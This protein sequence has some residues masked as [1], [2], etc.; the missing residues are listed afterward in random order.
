MARTVLFIQHDWEAVPGYVGER[1]A[2]RGLETTTLTI[3]NNQAETNRAVDFGE[4]GR[5]DVIVPLGSVFSV[6]DND[7]IGNWIGPELDFL[8]R[9]HAEDIPILGI[10]FG[11]QALAAAL[12]G[13]VEQSPEPE[14][15]W[16]RFESDRPDEL[17]EGPWMQWHYDR[18]SVPDGATELARSSVGPQAFTHGRSLGLQFHPEVSFEIVTSWLNGAPA[19][20]L[21]KPHV[22]VDK[23]RAD[24]QRLAPE[25]RVRTNRLVDWF[26]DDIAALECR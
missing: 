21:D 9:A 12:G 8:A 25:A 23:I 24:S 18:F 7:S 13:T 17:A 5:F 14:V 10:C 19:G 2:E 6:Y 16:R 26:L 3:A 4:P 1:M 11:G 20:E 22:D 15:G